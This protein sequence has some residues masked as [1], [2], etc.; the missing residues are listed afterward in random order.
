MKLWLNV[1]MPGTVWPMHLFSNVAFEHYE[2]DFLNY[3][4]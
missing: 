2:L 1:F 3:M 4:D